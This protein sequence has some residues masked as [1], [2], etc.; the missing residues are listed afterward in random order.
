MLVQLTQQLGWIINLEKS[1][2][3]P[4]TDFTFLGY[5]FILQQG[6]VCPTEDRWKK[7]QEKILPFL[8]LTEM[9]AKKW[10]SLVG[11]LAATEKMV[12]L[13]MLRM[14]PIQMGLLNVWNPF[15][16]NPDEKI[17]VT[18]NVRHAMRWWLNRDNV[19]AGVPL[20]LSQVEHQVF[21]DASV[22]GWGGHWE[23]Q[24]IQGLWKPI[25]KQYHINVL[26]LLAVWKV[27]EHFVDDLSGTSVLV[28]TDNSTTTAYISKQGGTRS[29]E[30]LEI[31][32]RF[33]EWL[34][35]AQI[36][37]KCRHIPGR[38]NVLADQLSRAG[39]VIATEWSIHPK[40]LE[41]V[42]MKWEKPMVDLFATR[43][44]YKLNSYVS[45]IPDQ[46]ALA[47]DAVNKLG[48]HDSVCFSSDSDIS[49]S[50]GETA[51]TRLQDDS[52]STSM[53]ETEMVP[54]V[55]GIDDRL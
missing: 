55:I 43:D 13:G 54:G 10:M 18:Q 35:E 8:S 23:N 15:S 1:E 5:Q 6:L 50:T 36:T 25:E 21:T 45:P 30:M 3:E 47:V 51:N 38:L 26:E 19:M 9:T 40:I 46:N 20:R 29:Q 39:Q 42:W 7:I 48:Q 11:T 12:K 49:K 31:T 2:L 37:I 32:T 33:Y 34:E 53:A 41:Y 4:K 17:Q 28:A 44:N 27:L 14:R 24:T 16:G 52:H 22:D